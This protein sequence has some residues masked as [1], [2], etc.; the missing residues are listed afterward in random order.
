[1]LGWQHPQQTFAPGLAKWV[2]VKKRTPH[3]SPAPHTHLPFRTNASVSPPVL[4]SGV[5]AWSSPGDRVLAECCCVSGSDS[6][7]MQPL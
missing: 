5:R 4:A 7:L 3:L 1:M 6:L 2:G